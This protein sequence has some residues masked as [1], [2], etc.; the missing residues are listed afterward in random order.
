MLVFGGVVLRATPVP[1]Q[2]APTAPAQGWTFTWTIM[3]SMQGRAAPAATVTFDVAVWKGIARVTPRSGQPAARALLATMGVI[4]VS[5][6]DSMLTVLDVSRRE[7]LIAASGELSAMGSAAGSMQLTVSDVQSA[8]RRVGAA[9]PMDAY[10]TTR[11]ILDERY[12]MSVRVQEMQRTLRVSEVSAL[13]M[14]AD[15]DSRDP[16]FRAFFERFLRG[17]GKPEAVRAVLRAQLRRVPGGVP[18]RMR[19]VTSTVTGGDTARVE[20]TGTMSALQRAAVDTGTFRV[21]V[22]YRITE[23]RRLLQPRPRP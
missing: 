9:T 14:S 18:V 8:L 2:A 7:A 15:L 22:G 21:P 10:G 13:D 17:L 6:R 12:A 3:S 4:L 11:V 20:A 19:V 23:V 1:A 16:G 5:A